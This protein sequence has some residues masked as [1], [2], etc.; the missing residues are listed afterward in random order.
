MIV[1]VNARAV[2][3]SGGDVGEN[4]GDIDRLTSCIVGY[5]MCLLDSVT[6]SLSIL[7]WR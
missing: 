1:G 7:K 4:G 6:L 3:A 2:E 5:F